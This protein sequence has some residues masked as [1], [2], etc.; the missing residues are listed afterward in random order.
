[1][2]NIIERYIKKMTK[3]DINNFAISKNIN[4]SENELNFT[5]DFVKKNYQNFF[6]NPKLFDINRYRS[7]YSA[8]NFPKIRKVW[9]EYYHKFSNYL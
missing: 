4:L 3:D 9:D 8:D 1:M 2:Y 7:N 6:A 5:Y